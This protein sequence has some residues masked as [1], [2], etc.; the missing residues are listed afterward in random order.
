MDSLFHFVFPIICALAAKVHIKHGVRNIVLL[1]I[2][3]VLID[4]D[5]FIYGFERMLF[6]NIFFTIILPLFIIFLVFNSKSDYYLKG[7]SVMLFLFLSSHILLD[8]ITE[9]G[10][11]LLYPFSTDY[12]KLDFNVYVPIASKF[13]GEGAIISST[14]VG[15]SIFAVI[16]LLPCIFLDE[17]IFIMEK[18]HESF[19]KAL[20]DIKKEMIKILSH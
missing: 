15:L 14:G 7:F 4:I 3:T 11:A 8:V 12:Y 20:K 6:H 9:P 17:I 1:G 16:I 5:H 19:R 2:L 13:S 18:K 10:V